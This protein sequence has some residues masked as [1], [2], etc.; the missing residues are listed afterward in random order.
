[1]S[2][3]GQSLRPRDRV[4]GRR[5]VLVGASWSSF[6]WGDII[7]LAEVIPDEQRDTTVMDKTV[8]KRKLLGSLSLRCSG[9]CMF[10]PMPL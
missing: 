5:P 9:A 2:T 7:V 10:Y 3:R 1:M 8:G 4:L 6:G